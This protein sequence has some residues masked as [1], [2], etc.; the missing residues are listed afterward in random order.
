MSSVRHALACSDLS[1]GLLQFDPPGGSVRALIA[2]PTEATF[3]A[4][5]VTPSGTAL[6]GFV[7]LKVRSDGSFTVS[8]HMHDSGIPDYDFQV[9]AALV[10]CNGMAFMAQ[11]SGHVEGTAS[12]TLTHA[13][14]RDD[15]HSESGTSELIS[16]FWPQVVSGSLSVAK[17]YSPTGVAGFFQDVAKD[18]FEVGAGVVGASLGVVIALS[19]E[20]GKIFGDLGVGAAFGVIAG[21]VVFATGGGAVMAVVAGVGVGL[22]TNAMIQQRPL[23]KQEADFV[24]QVFGSSLPVGKIRVTNLS[25]LGGR[26]FTMPGSDGNIY[27]NIG[28]AFDKPDTLHYNGL[29]G[30]GGNYTFVSG[31]GG[32]LGQILMHEMTHAWQIDHASFLP[33]LVCDGIVNQA[34]YTTGH[35]VYD[36]GQPGPPWPT[37]LEAQGA[38]VDQWFGRNIGG[39]DASGVPLLDET[40]GEGDPYFG[41][42]AGNI[43]PGVPP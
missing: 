22:V 12:T 18:V 29:D 23:S 37:N 6:G 24:D 38:L 4:D 33:G 8:F 21:V 42:I 16:T 14:N 17:D 39:M 40:K 11:H 1:K 10:A 7:D 30:S 35:E 20:V 19:S 34:N 36:F 26:A 32:Y 27:I 28:D 3:H 15:D 43:R 5:V 13:P 41:F 9:R 25:G 2:L 31:V